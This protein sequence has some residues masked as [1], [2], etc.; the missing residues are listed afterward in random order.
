MALFSVHMAQHMVLSMLAPILLLL[1]API[2]LALRVLPAAGPA[3]APRRL[4]LR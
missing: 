1:G 2:T 4:L 3:G